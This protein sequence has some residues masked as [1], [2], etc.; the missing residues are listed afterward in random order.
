MDELRPAFGRA[1]WLPVPSHK[2]PP[3]LQA[4]GKTANPTEPW[5]RFG[6]AAFL[7]DEA[8]RD[9]GSMS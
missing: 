6:S 5:D 8:V 4:R 9:N 3:G 2:A 1:P 7:D